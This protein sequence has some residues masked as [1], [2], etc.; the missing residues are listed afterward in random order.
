VIRVPIYAGVVP[1]EI[2][3][4]LSPRWLT[5]GDD[6]YLRGS[7]RPLTPVEVYKLSLDIYDLSPV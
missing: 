2:G 3:V 6:V 5:G 7:C 4:S 1:T